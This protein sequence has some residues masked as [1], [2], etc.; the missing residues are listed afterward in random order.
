MPKLLRRVPRYRRHKATGQAVVTLGGRDHYLGRYGTKTSEHLYDR[1]V[2]EWLAGGR[3]PAVDDETDITVAELA[4]EYMK[5]AKQHYTKDG[6][7]TGELQALRYALKPLTHLY[8]REPVSEFGPLRLEAVRNQMIEG[9]WSRGNVNRAVARV[10]RVFK[11]GVRK[12]LVPPSV[13]QSLTCVDGLQ[14]GRTEAR[15]NAPVMPVADA[16]VE[17][18]L[19]HLPEVV[20]SMVLLQRRTGMRPAEVCMLRPVDLDR[21]ADVWVYRPE[22]HKTEHHGRERVVYIGPQGQAELL[23]YLARDAT[24]YCFRPCDSMK[25]HL[26]ERLANRATAMT[27]GNA[28][29]TN[30]V[31]KPKRS[32]GERYEVASYRRAIHRACDLAEVERWSPN[33]LRHS[34][35]TE[36]RRDFGLE[37]AQ[38][39]L[40]HASASVTQVYA[41]RDHEKAAAVARAIG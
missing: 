41:E 39:V 14:R 36:V 12:Q 20:A 6:K 26:A 1:L 13:H 17:A 35:A 21:S 22:S 3:R 11:W 33:R 34:A 10:R 31:K 5:Y 9:G 30:R 28:P 7:P 40:G 15:E 25:K 37:A 27:Q 23:K 32:P 19:E 4:V 29:G 38:C 2:A 8:G 18:T 16:V 24:T